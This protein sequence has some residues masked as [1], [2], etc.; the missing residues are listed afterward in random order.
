MILTNATTA[1]VLFISV[2][3]ITDASG[4][5]A[6]S[7]PIKKNEINIDLD[8]I[9]P[10]FSYSRRV[11]DHMLVGIGIGVGPSINLALS[12]NKLTLT[13]WAHIRL[14]YNYRISENIDIETGLHGSIISWGGEGENEILVGG[15]VGPYLVAM[16]GYRNFKIGTLL[17]AGLRDLKVNYTMVGWIPLILRV[18]LPF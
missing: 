6:Q 10:S 3:A 7:V 9:F 18:S 15:L 13:E 2:L 16:L 8:L 5:K 4:Q 1:F 11:H 14:I 12:W 17:L